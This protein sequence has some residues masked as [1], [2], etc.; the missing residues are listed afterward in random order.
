MLRNQAVE[1]VSVAEMLEGRWGSVEVP[2]GLPQGEGLEAS[3]SHF[4]QGHSPLP[5]L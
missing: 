2:L 4:H 1:M 5:I 3:P